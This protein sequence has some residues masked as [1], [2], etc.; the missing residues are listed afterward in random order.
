MSEDRETP[1]GANAA[2]EEPTEGTP[3]KSGVGAPVEEA[4]VTHT[5]VNAA[6]GR[7]SGLSS[8]PDATPAATTAAAPATTPPTNPVTSNAGAGNAVPGTGSTTPVTAPQAP[9][10]R[11]II[12][13]PNNL[14]TAGPADTTVAPVAPAQQLPPATK[15]ADGNIVISADHPMAALYMQTPSAPELRGNRGAGVLISLLATIVFALVFAGV[16]ALAL[17]PST[18]PS[19]FVAALTDAALW[20]VAAASLTF[21][22]GLAVLVLIVGRAGWWAY[23]LGGFLVGVLVWLGTI[24]GVAYATFL[25]VGGA[26]LSELVNGD[27]A[28]GGVTP[29]GLIQAL[30]LTLIPIAAGIVAREATVWF[31]AW[32][33]ARGRKVTR[34]NAEA[35]TEYEAALAEAQAKQP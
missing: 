10:Q 1:A 27:T 30:G 28:G 11:P 4:E 21:F 20:P 19:Q 9:E 15:T 12:A 26:G 35:I 29:L 31:G 23:V 14:P 3:Q 33:G 24:V 6:V 8:E 13:E 7:A 5:D 25:S 17:A 2:H 32:I 22:I 18:P 34:K 16:I